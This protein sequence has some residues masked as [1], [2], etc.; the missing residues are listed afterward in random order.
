M[1]EEKVTHRGEKVW[2]LVSAQ[3]ILGETWRP[4]HLYLTNK[5][6]CWWYDFERKLVFDVPLD[7]M[8]S[9]TNEIRKTSGLDSNKEK[10]LDIILSIFRYLNLF[11]RNKWS[12][13]TFCLDLGMLL[14]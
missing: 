14:L 1:E 7:R 4:G 13:H 11:L 5:R 6:L 3:G 9:V 12:Q 10:V 8:I 2:Y